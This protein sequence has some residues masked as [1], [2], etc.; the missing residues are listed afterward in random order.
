[1]SNP[2]LAFV[3]R[4]EGTETLEIDVYDDIGESWWGEETVSAKSVRRTLKEAKGAKTI[5]LRVN[6]RGGDVF[7]GFAIYNLL[8]EHPARVEADVDALAASMAS[9]IIMAADEIRI[10]ANAMIMVHNP[11]SFALGEAEDLRGTADLLDKLRGQM[12]DAYVARTGLARERVIEMMDAETW[13]TA[14][15]AKE[16]GFVDLVKPSQKGPE[17]TK[18]LASID[19]RGFERAP[20]V[21]A[22]AIRRARAEKNRAR[23]P[24]G[25][26]QQTPPFAATGINMSDEELQELRD[27]LGLGEEATGRDIIDAVKALKEAAADDDEDDDAGDD[28]AM[29]AESARLRSDLAAANKRLEEKDAAYRLAL[30]E[31]DEARTKL[32]AYADAEVN[33]LVEKAIA[34]GRAHAKNRETLKRLAKHDRKAFDELTG[35]KAPTP[36]VDPVTKP[37]AKGG[38]NTEGLSAREQYFANSLRA[39]RARGANGK[40][41]TGDELV[42]RAKEMAAEEG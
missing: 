13:M 6:S 28:G 20:A 5:L 8:A 30:T 17:K 2:A 39:A 40:L 16:H 24:K 19:L 22:A 25:G 18:A 42:Q 23:R 29:D 4:G 10:A 37:G 31:R 1:M 32:E 41:L 21:F 15:E 12:V 3:V 11:W 34:D 27:L 26:A 14:S 7:D 38:A 36:I 35:T 9:V 33:D